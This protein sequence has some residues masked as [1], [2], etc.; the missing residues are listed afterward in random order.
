MILNIQSDSVFFLIIYI[1]DVLINTLKTIPIKIYNL[2]YK[3]HIKET[4]KIA[5]PV[6]IGQLG[7]III[8]QVDNLMI[9]SLGSTQLAA[10]ALANG[11]FFLVVVFGFGVSMAIAPITSQA[12]GANKGEMEKSDIL[13][14]GLKIIGLLSVLF[15]VVLFGIA[16]LLPYLGQDPDVVPLAQSYLRIIAISTFPM[17]FFMV[18]KHFIDGFGETKPGMICMGLTVL[19]NIFF[20]WILIY[21]KWGI[22][23]LGLDGA[24]WATFISRLLGFL[25]ILIFALNHSH[26]KSYFRIS[27]FLIVNREALRKIIKIGIPS[28]MQLFFEV[29]AF[30]GAVVLAGRIGEDPQSAHQIAISI[31][32]FTYMFYMGI[33]AAGS[34]RIGNAYG[35]KDINFIRKA[36]EASLITSL[37]CVLFFIALIILMREF[38]STLYI[39]NPLVSPIVFELL[40]FA[41]VFQIFDGVQAV[42]QGILRG[43]EDVKL[44]ALVA[45]VSYWLIG[46]PFAWF[47]SENLGWGVNG[48][49]VAL[50]MGLLFAAILLSLRFFL[51]IKKVQFRD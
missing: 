37:I 12:I 32:S 15:V 3:N 27:S 16:E 43:I 25:C 14:E 45:F 34:I 38:L 10:S 26:F 18:C 31:A 36:G 42:A 7:H 11:M 20:N 13:S 46:L 8:G 17:L 33:A 2:S 35:R 40:L 6:I 1:S 44:P 19:F 41:A 51:L 50:T 30:A 5:W 22:P 9:G 4:F 21:G 48:I 39:D 24:G 29:G 28:G 49:W 23:A 47:F